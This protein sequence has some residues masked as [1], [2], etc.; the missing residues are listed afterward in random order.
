MPVAWGLVIGC[1]FA[2]EVLVR[3]SA[4]AH[5]PQWC[6]QI[7]N[8]L[9]LRNSRR[10]NHISPFKRAKWTAL[11]SRCTGKRPGQLSIFT[12]PSISAPSFERSETSVNNSICVAESE[13]WVAREGV[14]EQYRT[15][16]C[17]PS[18]SPTACLWL[19]AITWEV[20]FYLK[21]DIN[22]GQLSSELT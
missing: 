9:V 15:K 1:C 20:S 4:S 19:Q 13:R 3:K 18:C 16:T 2:N 21:G 12:L 22:L 10:G 8:R 6:I 17:G 7:Q 14:Q 5:E 11:R